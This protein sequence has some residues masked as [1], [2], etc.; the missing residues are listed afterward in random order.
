MLTE[1]ICRF[2]MIFREIQFRTAAE[3]GTKTS[4]KYISRKKELQI[5][6]IHFNKRDCEIK[7]RNSRRISS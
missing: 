3:I 5:A 4:L 7:E 2:L 1:L 6:Q